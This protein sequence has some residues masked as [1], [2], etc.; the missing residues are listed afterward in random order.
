MKFSF[1][2]IKKLALGPYSKELLIEKLNMHSF[3][4]V[5]LG[6]DILEIAITPNR[7]SDAASHIGIAREASAIMK[8]SSFKELGIKDVKPDVKKPGVF[9]V[10]IKDKDFCKRYIATYVS[11][12]KVGPSPI[13]MKNALESCGLRSINNVVDTMNYVMLELGQPLHAFDADMISGGVVVRKARKNEKL[14]TIDAKEL[15]LSP[16]QLVIADA[17]KALA[18]AGIKGGKQ[19]E[20]S[21]RTTHILVESAN[22]DGANIYR[23]S[24]ALGLTTDASVRF[25]HNLNPELARVAMNRVLE[26]LREVAGGKVYQSVDVYP[27]KMSRQLIKFDLARINALIGRVFSSREAWQIF[28]ALGFRK[29]GN[30]AEV[31]WYR[32]D[33]QSIEDLAEEIVRIHGYSSL[34]AKP[35]MISLTPAIQQDL[36]IVKDQIRSILAGVGFSE[37]YNYSFLPKKEVG[38]GALALENPISAQSEFLRDHLAPHIARNL[39]ENSKFSDEVRIFEIGNVFT[40]KSN[41]VE[42]RTNLCVAMYGKGSVLEIKGLVDM[43]FGRLGITEYT[44]LETREGGLKFVADT[45]EVGLLSI[46]S[47]AKN[48]AVAELDLQLLLEL[49]SEEKEFVPLSKYPAIVRDLSV[50]VPADVRVGEILSMIQRVSSKLV[51]DVDLIDFYEPPFELRDR[52]K[53]DQRR[54]KSLTFRIVFQSEERTLTDAEA[55]KEMAVINQVVIDTFDAELR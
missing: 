36:L 26:L 37:V 8:L 51:Q 25:S 42:E 44:T 14:E 45:K 7:F 46:P 28:Q 15:A 54:K 1:S 39:E 6:G 23:S 48:A 33:V 30:F 2:L 50:F 19:S 40:K 9:T 43:L 21:G 13:W 12:V 20:V 4:A 52:S 32:A 11:N 17:E 5:D 31:P 16:N 27:K 53:E 34:V 49:I 47:R 10:H 3:E 38:E 18:V 55:D 35:P 29:K 22:F 24:R 41:L